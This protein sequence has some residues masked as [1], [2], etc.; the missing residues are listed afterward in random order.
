MSDCGACIYTG[1]E[2]GDNGFHNEM[3]TSKRGRTCCE[4][5]ESIPAGTVYEY[6]TYRDGKQR[7][8]HATCAV[9]AE[10]AWAFMCDGRMYESLWDLMDDDFFESLNTACF[11]RLKTPQA[12]AELQRRWMEWKGLIAA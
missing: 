5:Q 11:A 6:A 1:G 10:I 7:F 9:C 3:R 8:S 12:K 2:Y 4:C